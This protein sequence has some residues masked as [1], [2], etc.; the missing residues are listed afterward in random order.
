MPA[1]VSA[2]VD[3]GE[4]ED[5]PHAIDRL[6]AVVA[7]LVALPDRDGA[8]D[9]GSRV[10]DGEEVAYEHAIA[11]LEHVERHAHPREHH[12]AQ[13][14]HRQRATHVPT[15]APRVHRASADVGRPAGEPRIGACP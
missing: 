9:T 6:R 5:A 13:R 7:D 14:E 3:L 12:G 2:T 10:V 15:L 4:L 8:E 11:V 1:V